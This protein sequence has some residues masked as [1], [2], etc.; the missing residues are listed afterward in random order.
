MFDNSLEE[1]PDTGMMPQLRILEL[2]NN[3][4]AAIPSGYF[5]NMPALQVLNFSGNLLEV[6][7]ASLAGCV[8][9][10][11]L[12]LHD[13]KLRAFEEAA[14]HELVQL[15]TLFLQGNQFLTVP[16]SLGRCE[17][18]K[19]INVPSASN[20]LDAVFKMR[21]LAAEGGK[22]WDKKGKLHENKERDAP[23]PSPGSKWG[24]ARRLS[25]E[26]GLQ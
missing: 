10:Q 5:A 1:M 24:C 19:Q 3:R 11:F 12:K 9:L 18:L 23:E 22:Y 7:P 14:W 16:T 2:N 25:A 26:A 6:V 8:S 21:A 15:E 17:S 13:N 4:I 20:K